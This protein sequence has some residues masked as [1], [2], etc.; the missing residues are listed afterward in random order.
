MTMRRAPPRFLVNTAAI[1]LWPASLCRLR[2]NADARAIA[3]A[4]HVLR[5]KRDGRVL[6]AVGPG[7][8]V[9][10]LPAL[11]REP[12]LE[13][14]IAALDVLQ[15]RDPAASALA[16]GTLPGDAVHADNAAMGLADDYAA[17]SGLR[18]HE[19][20]RLLAFA[21]R[22]RYH[23]A[24]WLL[25]PAARAWR[26]MR[27]AALQDGVMLEAISGFRSHLYQR[28]IFER[29]FARGLSLDAILRVNAAPGHSEHHSGC[30]VDIGTPGDRPAEEG[31]EATAAFAWLRR[32]AA[33]FG[34]TMSY[35]RDN[36]H[37]ITYEPWHWCWLSPANA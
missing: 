8:L 3:A 27:A 26:A 15:A 5:R 13:A 9:P 36:P 20:P 22:D 14:A 19:E 34:F 21:G 23:R 18:F 6:A 37:G 35:P 28:G 17:S 11:W 24:L 25:T 32:R 2:S 4:E 33:D 12:G 1:E 30:A 10:L 16:R 31:F 29:K 7:G